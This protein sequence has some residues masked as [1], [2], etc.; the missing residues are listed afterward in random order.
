MAT[1]FYAEKIPLVIN[2]LYRTPGRTFEQKDEGEKLV[3]GQTLYVWTSSL[4]GTSNYFKKPWLK[5]NIGNLHC[6]KKCLRTR[7]R[8]PDD[9]EYFKHLETK[10]FQPDH[11][12]TPINDAENLHL[13]MFIVKQIVAAVCALYF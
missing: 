2:I 13:D 9:L 5:K 10:T 11:H 8:F 1:F 7:S 12:N 6:V 4:P 3:N